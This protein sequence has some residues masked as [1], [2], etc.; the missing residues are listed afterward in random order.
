MEVKIDQ[1]VID[2]ACNS[3]RASQQ[4]LKNQLRNATDVSKK[5]IIESQLKDVEEALRVFTWL[6]S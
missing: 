5:A 1:K 2:T 3:L 4:S 6:E